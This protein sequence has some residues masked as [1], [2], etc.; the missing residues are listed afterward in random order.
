MWTRALLKDNAKQALK[1]RYW[2]AFL[3]CLVL[4]LLGVGSAATSAGS[5]A[6]DVVDTF[7]GNSES[8]TGYWGGGSDELLTALLGVSVVMV[9]LY[10]IAALCWKIFVLNPLEV[11]RCRFF[12]ENRQALTP[13]GTVAGIFH[14]PYLNVV[15]VR[16]F[17]GLKVF[18]GY[19]LLIVPG[20]YW[21]FCY[22][23]VPY[24]LAE[25][26]Y[27][28]T[29]R[30]ME[31]SKQ[32]MDGEKWNFFVLELSFIGWQLLCV[33]T[34]G[35]GGFFLEPYMQATNAEF[36]AAM[37]SKAVCIEPDRQNRAGR[38]CAPRQQPVT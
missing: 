12:M 16:L 29:D 17:V 36:Y 9:I 26:P 14:T 28:T 20:I 25:N 38:L 7:S 35:I 18:A 3:V 34:F 31:L 30:A 10:W 15:K 2:R 1:G 33:L 21:S 22:R 37:R 13:V 6:R 11:G 19:I 32:I 24:L 5:S 23:L 27:M 8:V 4:T